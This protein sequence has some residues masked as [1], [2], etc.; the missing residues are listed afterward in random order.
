MLRHTL[1]LNCL[2]CFYF[3]YF[4]SKLLWKKDLRKK[5]SEKE[6]PQ[7]NPSPLFSRPG[8][9]QPPPWPACP[10]PAPVLLPQPAKRGP[11]NQAGP[12][13]P[14]LLLP[15][16]DGRAPLVSLPLPP[17]FFFPTV[18]RA[19]EASSPSQTRNPAISCLF[20]GIKPL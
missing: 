10:S 7:P 6:N 1:F 2:F 16:T 13:A 20:R 18:K 19:G 5:K 17:S 12:R 11:P 15:F 4:A 14:S 3:N 9:A 8:A